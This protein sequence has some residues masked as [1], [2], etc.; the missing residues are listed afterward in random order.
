L[1]DRL[2]A[3]SEKH[4]LQLLQQLSTLTETDQTSLME[5]LLERQ[6]D[7]AGWVDGKVVQV[8]WQFDPIRTE[9]F[10]ST[11]F[12]QGLVAL[13]PDLTLDY[14]PLQ[15]LLWQQDFQQADR[16][17]LSNLCSLAGATAAKRGW[18]YFTEVENFPS[19]D[20]QTINRLWQVYSEGKFGFAV[21][22]ELWISV[23]RNWDKLWSK[24][25]W[26]TGNIWTRYPQEFIWDLSAPRGHLPLSNQL[27]GV[28]V[29]AALLA[30]PAWNENAIAP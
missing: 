22:R 19:A 1:R 17:T 21:Q 3:E 27:R 28:R 8:L 13:P 7:P 11:H 9:T 30:H 26:R 4:Q 12:P 20:L 23:D 18:L 24:I 16:L 14:A 6:G 5:F 25:G 29:I 15:R 2:Q 10:L